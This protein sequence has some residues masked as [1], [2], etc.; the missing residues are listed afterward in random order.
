LIARRCHLHPL[1][2]PGV[3]LIS[4]D[5][6]GGNGPCVGPVAGKRIGKREILALYLSLAPYGNQIHGAERAS[7]AYFG[8]PARSFATRQ[9]STA[10]AASEPSLGRESAISAASGGSAGRM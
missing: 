2:D 6:L 4:G 7:R 8:C 5:V 10:P 3:E 1:L 9:S